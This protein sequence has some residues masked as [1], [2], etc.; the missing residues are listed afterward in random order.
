VLPWRLRALAVPLD[1]TF[2]GRARRARRRWY[3]PAVEPLPAEPGRLVVSALLGR[4]R[5]ARGCG[6]PGDDRVETRAYALKRYL[7][8]LGH[9][10]RS[11]RFATS[12]AQLVVGVTPV[13]GWGPVPRDAAGRARFVRA[14]RKSVQRWL[15]DLQ[16]AGVIAHEPERDQAGMW[17]RTQIVLLATPEPDTDELAVARRR[18]R[19]WKRRE[20]ARQRRGRVAPSLGGIRGRSGVPCARRRARVAIERRSQV[21][22]RARRAGVEEQLARAEAVRANRRDLTHPFGAPPTS[23]LARVSAQPLRSFETAGGEPAARCS[24]QTITEVDSA[25]AGTGARGRAEAAPAAPV[26]AT[27]RTAGTEGIESMSPDDFDALVERRL[28]ARRRALAARAE[29]LAPQIAARVREVLAWPVG[30]VCPL[31]RLREAWVAHRYGLA[32]VVQSGTAL[33]GAVRPGLAPA[34]GRAIRLYEAHADRCPDGWPE[35]GAAALCALAGQ[36]R[37]NVF[38]GDVARLLVLA[39]GM[40]ALALLDDRRR[41]E[42]ARSRAAARATP[43]AGRYTLNFRV[44]PRIETAEQRRQ[45]VR[46][47]VLLLGRDPAV[48]PNAAL[49][50]E[51]LSIAPG[52]EEVRLVD[53]DPCAELDGTGA[54]AARYRAEL[55][56]GRWLLPRDWARVSAPTGEGENS[57]RCPPTR[58]VRTHPTSDQEA[59]G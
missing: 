1:R 50:L 24:A 30:A 41:V 32:M 6:T 19:G 21:R 45:R 14:R 17:W 26:A 18:A 3:R 27:A 22:E 38:A 8:R 48:W 25:A 49:A 29:L 51:H 55:D 7:F 23:A 59:T 9:A 44:T 16:A 36:R 39:K 11:A 47:A 34:I 42:R 13:I 35:S 40:R 54:R 28:A 56:Q 33:A 12:I 15:D 58:C 10:Q 37:A 53:V 43:A 46:D 4:A 57:R 20:R 31:G 52:A 2:A 5:R